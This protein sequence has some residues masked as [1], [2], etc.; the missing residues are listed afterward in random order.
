[1][2][3]KRVQVDRPSC[4]TSGGQSG[5]ISLGDGVEGVFRGTVGVV[6]VVVVD[7]EDEAEEDESDL[8]CFVRAR[9]AAT[10]VQVRQLGMLLAI[11]SS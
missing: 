5:G 9:Q 7:E 11:G 10:E 2:L 8:A 3:C 6:I 1:M 4:S